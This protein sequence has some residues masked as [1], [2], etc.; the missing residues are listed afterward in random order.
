[1][2]PQGRLYRTGLDKLIRDTPQEC[3]Y[4]DVLIFQI[5]R[6]FVNRFCE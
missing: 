1:M 5:G 3:V 6:G 2:T 4:Q